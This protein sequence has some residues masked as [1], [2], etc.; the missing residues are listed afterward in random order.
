MAEVEERR[1][2]GGEDRQPD[3]WRF[4]RWRSSVRLGSCRGGELVESG[5]F[6]VN[7]KRKER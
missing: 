7:E 1:L 3:V 2:S 5:C 6:G 4:R